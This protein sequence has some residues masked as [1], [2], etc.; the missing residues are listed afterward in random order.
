VAIA[1]ASVRYA[2]SASRS[3]SDT[4][5]G[6]L[7]EHLPSAERFACQTGYFRFEAL[8]SFADEITHMLA[9]GGRFDLAVGVNE[10]RLTA[11]DLEETL[12]LVEEWIP[13]Q[14][15]FTVIGAR[16]GLF[17]PKTYHVT[18]PG[19]RHVA[20]VGS[21]NFTPPGLGHH[22]EA[23]VFLDDAEDDPSV[24]A[25]VEAA[26]LSWRE[27]ATAAGLEARPVT[28]DLI[29]DLTADQLV[30]P[31]PAKD[32]EPARGESPRLR[33]PP[34]PSI[35]GIPRRRRRSRPR[36]AAAAG[37]LR[38]APA[39]FLP[40]KVGIVKRLSRTDVKGFSARPGTPYLALPPNP[41][42]LADRLPLQPEGRHREPRLDVLVE[43]RLDCDLGQP[44]DSSG[45]VASITH[46]GMGVTQKSKRDLRFNL[47]HNL[48][49]QLLRIA[50]RRKADPPGPGDAAAIEFLDGG[51][52]LR[53]TFASSE[54]LK[55]E[56]LRFCEGK[57]WG[58]LPAG[59]TPPW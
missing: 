24:L 14:A 3:V 19:D 17:H 6:W 1:C 40:G 29:A 45:E 5:H 35:D 54:P 10:E 36:K 58:W 59:A 53:L 2:D 30:D 7:V 13:T 49:E 34:L 39:G 15:S 52:V 20:A 32:R 48:H 8:E 18:L 51:R 46:V 38:N 57:R 37:R 55:A 12:A 56:L 43:A 31:A 27:R 47:P 42:E 21:A 26:I 25:A 23:C 41:A 11:S 50:S 22:V 4:V 44:V 28:L 16:N 9:A 33:F